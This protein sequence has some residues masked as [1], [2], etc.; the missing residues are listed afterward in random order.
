MTVRGAAAAC[1]QRGVSTTTANAK[2][3]QHVLLD[4]LLLGSRKQ[5]CSSVEAS[6][7]SSTLGMLSKSAYVVTAIHYHTSIIAAGPRSQSSKRA[8]Y[9]S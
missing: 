3:P 9:F 1:L 4:V 5:G 2:P 7:S 6:L 8:L